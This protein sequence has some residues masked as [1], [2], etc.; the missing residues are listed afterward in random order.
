M[1]KKFLKVLLVLVVIAAIAFTVFWFARPA[2]V[3]FD[4]A[5]ATIPHAEYSHFA[6]I[7]GVRIHYQQKGTGTPLV[8]LHGF[9]SSTYSWKDVF[10]PLAKNF[11]VIA[12]DLKGFGFSGKP[13]GDYSRPA[14]A[15]L[16]IHLLDYLKVD[17]AWLCGNSMGGEIALNIAL[18]NPQR[19]GGLILVD[20][21]GVSING[22]GSL[23]PSYLL[24]PVLGRVLTALALTSDKLVREGLEKSFYD[25]SKVTGE[26]V[27]NYYRP[28]K[29][30]GGQLAAVRARIQS[31]QFPIEQDLNKINAPTLIL[32]GAEDELIP[33]EAGRKMNSLIK[34][35][36]LVV[37]EK[38]G[39]VPQEEIP[40]RV[41][42]EITNF[43]AASS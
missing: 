43:V 26:R 33:L 15:R 22:G 11:H 23:A 10:E 24:V 36:R 40:E 6:D 27:A 35:S 4:E 16:V 12:I 25:D 13:D 14:Q 1:M 20:S 32:W 42:K 2:D 29:T 18:E 9:T 8:L 21:S 19:V 41:V 30:R 17:K 39:H 3:S 28:L 5:R 34:T 37:I 38:C 7:D 31:E